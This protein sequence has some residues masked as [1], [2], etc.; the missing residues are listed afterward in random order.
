MKV[1]IG[2]T[3][4]LSLAFCSVLCVFSCYS[5]LRSLILTYLSACFLCPLPELYSRQAIQKAKLI[6]NPGCYA[7]SIQALIAPLVHFLD[8]QASPT[9]FGISGYSGA[10][11]KAAPSGSNSTGSSGGTVPKI[12]PEDLGGGVRPYSLTDHIHEREASRQLQQLFSSPP[13]QDFKVAFIPAVAPWFQG[14]IST[15]SAP[16]SQSMSA[17][18]VREAFEEF[19]KENGGLVEIGSKVPEIGVSPYLSSHGF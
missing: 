8:P 14:I 9:V 16:L 5:C 4:F 3:I 13:S 2:Q 10:G 18:N 15:L 1:D 12:T 6:S 7:T 11:T 19:Y 17:K